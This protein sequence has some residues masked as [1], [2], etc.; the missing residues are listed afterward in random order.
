M[1]GV[2]VAEKN[3]WYKYHPLD[4]Y[5]DTAGMTLE[6]IGAYQMVLNLIYM[7]QGPV[8]DNDAFIAGHLRIS[9]RKWRTFKKALLEAGKLTLNGG[10]LTNVRAKKEI[11]N[12]LKTSRKHREHGAKGARTRAEKDPPP[13]KNSDLSLARL[14]HVDKKREDKNRGYPPV[15]PP[16]DAAGDDGPAEGR[17]PDGGRSAPE[18]PPVQV[19]RPAN[20]RHGRKVPLPGGW[21]WQP[22]QIDLKYARSKG[23]SDDRI[24]QEADKFRTYHRAQGTKFADWHAGWRKWIGMCF[25]Q[26]GNGGNRGQRTGYPPASGGDGLAAARDIIAEIDQAER[27][28]AGGTGFAAPSA[29]DWLDHNALPSD[30]GAA[31]SLDPG[32]DAAMRPQDGGGASWHVIEGGQGQQ[33]RRG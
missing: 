28:D 13:N 8:E 5:H 23:F 25:D 21:G 30:G 29:A 20:D 10:Q 3:Q 9:T 33:K 6:Q 26:P 4:F 11:E 32:P 14:T 31:R 1:K 15:V 16:D 18:P 24:T 17:L 12:A 2:P 27:S 7:R 19:A 22:T